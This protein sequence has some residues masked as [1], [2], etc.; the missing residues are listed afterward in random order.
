M[1]RCAHLLALSEEKGETHCAANDDFVDNVEKRLNY[2]ELVRD[3]G[4]ADYSDEK[5]LW[6]VAQT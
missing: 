2:A 5:L 1:Q 4:T 6:L 3:L